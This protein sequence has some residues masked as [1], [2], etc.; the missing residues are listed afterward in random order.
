MEVDEQQINLTR[1]NL[2]FPE[3]RPFFLENRGLFA[4]GKSGEVDLFFSRRIGIDDNGDARADPG[5][6]AADRQGQRR[7]RRPAEH[8][9]R[10]RRPDARQQL[11]GGPREQGSAEPVEPSAPCSSTAPRPARLR[12][13][14]NWNRTFGVDG[15][16]GIARGRD[17]SADLRRRPRRPGWPAGEHAYSSAFEYRHARCTDWNLSYT[18]VGDNFN[19]EVG[20]LERPDG[21]R[22]VDRRLLPERPDGRAR[23]RRPARVAAARQLR[24]LLGLRRLSGDRDAAHRQRAWTSRTAYFISPALNVQ[25]E[26]L[27]EPFEV[28]PGVVV[29]AGKLST[30]RWRSGRRNTD[31]PQVDFRQHQLAG[32]RV[33]V[34]QPGQ[35]RASR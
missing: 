26:G 14:D 31:R 22:Q 7:Q 10:A 1:F 25:Y 29:P 24:E 8:A 27:R 12:G 30:V 5:R 13:I 2:L 15:R 18:E 20:F 28:Y 11:L 6:R 9:D 21:Y 33:P 35:L 23:Q 19:P 17:R 32:R 34:G 3:K 16:L 4:V